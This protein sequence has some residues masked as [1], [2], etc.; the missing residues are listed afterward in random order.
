MYIRPVPNF[1]RLVT[2][3]IAASSVQAVSIVDYAKAHPIKTWISE[4]GATMPN[5][6]DQT[7]NLK[8]GDRVLLLSGKDIDDLSG[9][10][11]LTVE[12]QGKTVPITKL[13]NAHLFLNHNRIS[14]LPDEIARLEGVQFIYLENNQLHDL[15]PELARMPSLE[16]MYFTGNQFTEI[17]PFVFTMT[18][19]KKLQFSKNAIA[20]LPPELGNLVELRHFNV[21][22]NRITEIPASISKLSKLRVCDLSDNPIR[23]LPEEFGKVSIVNQLRVRNTLLTSLPAG[24]ATMR[25]TIDVTGSRIDPATLSPALRARLS[26]EKPPGSKP[27]EKITVKKPEKQAN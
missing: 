6:T 25:A 20:L 17:P 8:E 5:A 23:T 27:P 26:T 3:L 2:F 10:S 9:I 24:F 4:K 19:L 16:G 1:L 7:N 13:R 12:D 22:N 15:P 11:T 21:A 14:S 18:R